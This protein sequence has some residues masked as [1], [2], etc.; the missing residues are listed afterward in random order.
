MMLRI[1][2]DT[3]VL[4]TNKDAAGVQDGIP[5]EPW[6]ARNRMVML[7][8]R[9]AFVGSGA[10]LAQRLMVAGNQRGSA[11]AGGQGGNTGAGGQGGST[12]AATEGRVDLGQALQQADRKECTGANLA[13][14]LQYNA[15]RPAT[16]ALLQLRHSSLKVRSLAHLAFPWLSACLPG[17]KLGNLSDKCA[18]HYREER[19]CLYNCLRVQGGGLQY[20]WEAHY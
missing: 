8:A 6:A 11:S 7:H 2:A 10:S 19:H 18:V 13:W 12:D 16:K 4:D 14:Y 9:A 3:H 5:D 20:H 15:P 17:L 1:A